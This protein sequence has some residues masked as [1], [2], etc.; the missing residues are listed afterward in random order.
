MGVNIYELTVVELLSDYLITRKDQQ[1]SA[2]SL[3]MSVLVD[4][5]ALGITVKAY[6]HCGVGRWYAELVL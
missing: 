5:C 6:V 1:I 2:T 3:K 4:G